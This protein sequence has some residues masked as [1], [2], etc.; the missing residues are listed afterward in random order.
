MSQ[1]QSLSST[2]SQQTARKVIG[3]PPVSLER[4]VE[5]FHSC[6]S[7]ESESYLPVLEKYCDK[8]RFTYSVAPKSFSMAPVKY[9]DYISRPSVAKDLKFEIHR[10]I[11]GDDGAAVWCSGTA[12]LVTDNKPYGKALFPLALRR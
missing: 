8:E 4:I 10:A 11:G 1:W 3:L 5:S 2:V 9:S 6:G 12:V 7:I